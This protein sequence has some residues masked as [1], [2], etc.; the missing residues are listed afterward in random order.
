MSRYTNIS[1]K[2]VKL[3]NSSPVVYKN[4]KYPEITLDF[5]DVYVYV[6]KGDRYD[7]LALTYYSD[8]SLWWVISLANPSQGASSLIPSPGSQVRIPAPSRIANILSEYESL[9]EI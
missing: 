2:K 9:N 6:T 1:T 4:V 3:E 7:T 8:I 5:E